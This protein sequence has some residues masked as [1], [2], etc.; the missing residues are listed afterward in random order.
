MPS[1]L[2]T[3]WTNDAQRIRAT[4][5]TLDSLLGPGRTT[6][7]T[8]TDF[9]RGRSDAGRCQHD[10]LSADPRAFVKIDCVVIGQSDATG[11]NVGSDLPGFICAM[12]AVQGVLVTL[13]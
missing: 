11:G 1:A 3:S 8:D 9:G 13:P 2:D 5:L 6:T 7:N 10:N 4:P 12:D